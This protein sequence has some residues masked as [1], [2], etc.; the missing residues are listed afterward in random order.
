MPTKEIAATP[1][2][3]GVS[4]WDEPCD[5]PA[6]RQCPECG[7]WFCETHFGDPEWHPCLEE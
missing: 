4:H 3:K 6:T 7:V 1:T 5:L 2:C